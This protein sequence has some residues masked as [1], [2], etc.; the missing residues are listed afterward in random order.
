MP[1]AVPA[2]SFNVESL[3]G[4]RLRIE[5]LGVE[6]CSLGFRASGFG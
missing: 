3:K 5:G 6:T 2:R 1:E 4:L